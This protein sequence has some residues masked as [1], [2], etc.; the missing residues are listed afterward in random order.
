MAKCTKVK[1]ARLTGSGER[2]YLATWSFGRKHV[3]NYS[4][5]FQYYAETSRVQKNK[6]G[7]IIKNSDGSAKHVWD[8]IDGSSSTVTSKQATY[9]APEGATKIRVRV[10]PNSTKTRVVKKKKTY[11]WTGA[12]S[13]YVSVYVYDYY[14]PEIPAVPTISVDDKTITVTCK[15]LDSITDLV[16]FYGVK[17]NSSAWTR[18]VKPKFGSATLSWSGASGCRYKFR[19]R[20]RNI[21]SRKVVKGSG[22]KKK[23]VTK[24]YEYWSDYS[25]YT[26]EVE[27]T[28]LPPTNF[29]ISVK[30]ETSVL[31]SWTKAVVADHYTIHYAN[32]EDELYKKSGE[33][34]K[35]QSTE[36]NCSS[37]ILSGLET[38]KV[39][40]FRV[41]S[42][43]S[44]GDESITYTKILKIA[45]GG[46][47]EAPTTWSSASVAY[48]G[49][50]VKLYWVHNSEDGSPQVKANIEGSI[51]GEV[52]LNET[53]NNAKD[54]Y[55]E[56]SDETSVYELDTTPYKDSDE[57][58]WRVRTMGVTNKYGDWSVQRSIHL[59]EKPSLL[60]NVYD[61]DG[62]QTDIVDQFP[63]NLK[64]ST[65]PAT[66]TPIGYNIT[67]SS[68]E[69]YSAVDNTGNTTYVNTDEEVFTRYIEG[70][71]LSSDVAL[72]LLPSDIDIQN[73]I[74]YKITGIVSFDSGL[75]ADCPE[76][77][78]NPTTFIVAIDDEKYDINGSV[79][80]NEDD[81]TVNISP[82][83]TLSEESGLE[84]LV[85]GDGNYLCDK[86]GNFL[87]G[88]FS[89]NN[90]SED[91]QEEE[92]SDIIDYAEGVTLSVHRRTANGK[93]VTIATGIEN[94]GTIVTDPHPALD[95]GRYRIVATSDSTG[96]VSYEDII[97]P[98]GETSIIIQWNEEWTDF[99]GE[100]EDDETPVWSGSLIKL[101]Y[102]IDVDE[103]NTLDVSLVSY[104]GRER[105]VSYYGTQLG[106][107]FKWSCEIPKDDTETLYQLRRLAVYPGDVYVR[108]PSGTGFWAQISVS[109]NIKHNTLTVPVSLD[110]KPVEGGM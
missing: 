67:I 18:N 16:R 17:N 32:S 80:Y 57:L 88:I 44:N 50:K 86:D 43:N 15:N 2:D 52:V 19:V 1:L 81:M 30:T 39:W 101:P 105:P 26:D 35:T 51:N 37:Y 53:V 96:A 71:G 94:N 27:T 5:Q 97:E 66:Q 55:G 21:V 11:W 12:Y 98:I 75:T 76:T 100:D 70:N 72:T 91:D 87:I 83:C 10:K 25:A 93:F 3:S 102:N 107:S 65:S 9:T 33:S 99:D 95:Y 78:D 77:G 69:A 58:M 90:N 63:I 13:G 6:K 46:D 7:K 47:P 20:A 62:K 85:D 40:Y 38:G 64:L 68:T 110:I 45:L 79:E 61:K 28:P 103:S 41:A 42:V 36:D 60:I 84:F 56:Y 89:P 29:K 8:W 59:Y 34:Y 49:E 24:K 4:V 48:I 104:I 108:E 31:L 74:T 109:F 73:G 22:K 92:E 14:A 106:E 54:E 23:T 82:Y